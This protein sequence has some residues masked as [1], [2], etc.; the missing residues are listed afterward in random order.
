[1]TNSANGKLIHTPTA[2]KNLLKTKAAG[3]IIIIYLKSEIHNDGRP[4]PRPSKAPDDVTDTADTINPILIMLSAV[5]PNLSVS[6]LVVNIPNSVDGIIHE[7]AVPKAIIIADNKSA[8][9]YI[10]LTRL[11]SPAP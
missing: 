11:C 5:T 3:M 2:P 6:G 8:V 10:C 7:S 4:F 1:M 9:L